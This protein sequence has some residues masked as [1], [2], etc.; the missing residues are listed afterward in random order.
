MLVIIKDYFSTCGTS[1]FGILEKW[2]TKVEKRIN[3]ES[4]RTRDRIIGIIEG[5]GKIT[6]QRVLLKRGHHPQRYQNKVV[7]VI[8][9]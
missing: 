7:H 8:I 4:G 3:L 6:V 9:Q 2:G 1:C 5:E